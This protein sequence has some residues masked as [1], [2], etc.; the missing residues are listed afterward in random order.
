MAQACRKKFI[1]L[2]IL[3]IDM[4]TFRKKSYDSY[5]QKSIDFHTKSHL[6]II[7]VKTEL[8]PSP[9]PQLRLG[10]FGYI[11]FASLLTTEIYFENQIKGHEM[12]SIA[13]C[14]SLNKKFT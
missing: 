10:I 5:V 9:R 1:K 2:I 12:C 14:M 7:Q 3:K 6:V 13:E 8:M 11:T 4:N